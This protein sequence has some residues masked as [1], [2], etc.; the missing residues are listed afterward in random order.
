MTGGAP[1]RGAVVAL[2]LAFSLIPPSATANETELTEKQQTAR[3]V[4][5]VALILFQLQLLPRFFAG[6]LILQFV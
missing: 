5:S 6:G 1:S 2:V 3:N 4:T